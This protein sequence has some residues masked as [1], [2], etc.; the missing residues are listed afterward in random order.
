MMGAMVDW[1]LHT[2]AYI[3][4]V[5]AVVLLGAA[6]IRWAMWGDRSRGRPRCPKCWYDMR[7]SLP[8][9]ECPECGHD[10]SIERNLYR[11]R[12]RWWPVVVTIGLPLLVAA[13]P[14]V[15]VVGW[16]RDQS[17]IQ[18]LNA[19]GHTVRPPVR[20]GPTWLVDRLPER[21][22]VRF[23]RAESVRLGDPPAGLSATD[24][25][26]AE[27]GKLRHL[28]RLS[29]STK[30][31]VTDSGAAHL[32]GLSRLEYLDLSRTQITDAGLRHLR[33]MKRLRRLHL[34]NTQIT[35]SGLAHLKRLT[36]LRRLYLHRTD[37]TDAALVQVAMLPQLRGLTLSGTKVTDQGVAGLKQATPKLEVVW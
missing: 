8:S 32:R 33:R 17:A 4:G 37:V 13:Y 11:D 16:H 6:L 3:L 2:G 26:L 28:R 31:P 5:S 7:G 18:N 35:D 14:L 21:Y 27:C 23:D 25:D 19:R 15:V 24:A 9:L 36:Q 1:F 34:H 20:T 12:R 22:A 30:S 29:L 10:A